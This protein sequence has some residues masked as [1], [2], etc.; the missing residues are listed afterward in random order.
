MPT[1]KNIRIKKP[2]GGSRMQRVQVLASGKY[3]FVKNKGR[4]SNKRRRTAVRRAAPRRRRTSM[5][6]RRKKQGRRKPKPSLIMLISIGA[7]LV[8]TYMHA[9]EGSSPRDKAG[10]ALESVIG[11]NL[12]A[13]NPHFQ[14]QKMFFTLPIVGGAVAKKAIAYTGAGRYFRGLPVTA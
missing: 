1:F 13:A 7:A 8:G 9:K 14:W 11:V 10:R 2:K 4:T 12:F 3:K 6:R 5:V